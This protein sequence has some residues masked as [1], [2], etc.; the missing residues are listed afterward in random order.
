MIRNEEFIYVYD[1][2]CGWCYG[3]SPVIERMYNEN[4]EQMMFSV[5]SGGLVTGERVAPVRGMAGYIRKAIPHLEQMT[6]VK[7]GEAYKKVLDEGDRISDSVPPAIALAVFREEHPQSVVPFI[8]AVQKANFVYGEDLNDPETYGKIAASFGSDEAQFVE[9]I[10]DPAYIQR[11]DDDFRQAAAFGI[12]GFPAVIY[13][14]D[15]KYFLLSRGYCEYE[16][17]NGRL[18]SARK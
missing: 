3:F 18:G 1:A 6:G 12:T 4:R 17:L 10:K 8:I 2:L 13:R 11:A 14:K 15:D 9:K 5:I 16:V 7:I